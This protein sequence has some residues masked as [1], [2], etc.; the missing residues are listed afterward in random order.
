MAATTPHPSLG[1]VLPT[2]LGCAPTSAD[3][4][5]PLSSSRSRTEH[6]LINTM[7]GEY[8]VTGVIGEGGMGTVFSG[9]QPLIGKRVAIKIL[10]S[11]LSDDGDVVDRFLAEAKAVN[12]I[13][14]PN[15]IDIFSFGT[16]SDGEQYFVMEHLEGC[17]LA[18]YMKEHRPVSYRAGRDILEQVL[19]A[20]AAAHDHG[21]VHRDL[22]PDN[23]YLAAR[24]GGGF[25]VKLLDF[26]VAKFTEEGVSVGRTRT[27]VPIGTPLYMS[28]EQ[29]RGRDVSFQS[30]LYSLGVIMYEMFTG[31]TPFAAKTVYELV[32]A[33]VS[34]DPMRPSSIVDFPDELERIILWCMAKDQASRPGSALTLRAAL[35]PVLRELAGP[36]ETAAPTPMPAI[37]E[38]LMDDSSSISQERRFGQS[39]ELRPVSRWRWVGLL[40]SVAVASAI[41]V[42]AVNYFSRGKRPG[43]QE[44]R[45]DTAGSRAADAA[46]APDARPKEA[47]K[48]VVQFSVHPPSAKAVI[49]VDGKIVEGAEVWVERSQTRRLKLRVEAEGYE[50]YEASPLPVSNLYINIPLTRASP[51]GEMSTPR[52]GMHRVGMGPEPRPR[53]AMPAEPMAPPGEMRVDRF[54]ML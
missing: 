25:M 31:R 20:L 26:G 6:T 12:K 27:G 15:I 43:V 18:A 8:R 54:D 46:I 29:C 52:P 51:A 50:P 4:G 11:N 38:D 9:E 34:R 28:P 19:D 39:T 24:P 49:R 16:L 13:R 2:D 30:D 3:S 48:I 14:H 10:K 40:M 23:I 1:G 17:S 45:A 41:A 44:Q 5:S 37:P 36:D 21:I 53:D 22:K 33:H 32:N 35:G 7:V 47:E 42:V